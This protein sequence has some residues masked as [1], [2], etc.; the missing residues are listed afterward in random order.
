MRSIIRAILTF[1]LTTAFACA[2]ALAQGRTRALL[3]ACSD[4]VSQ[5]DLG[6]A[7]SGNLHMI[8]S[9]LISADVSQNGLAIEDG[10]IGT[11]E[12]LDSAIGSAFSGSAEDDLSI[13]YLCTHGILSSADDGEIYLLLGDGETE[14]PLSAGQLY[15]L[16]RNI[17]GE[18]LLI[19]DACHSGALIGRGIPTPEHPD[20]RLP[21]SR[22]EAPAFLS[23]FLSDSSVHV[24]T[25]AGGNESSWY[26]D[27]KHLSSGA[28]SYFASAIASGLGLY[29]A[30]EADLSGDGA[31]TL[32]ELH[33]YLSTAV[34]SS[35]SQLLSSRAQTLQL[36]VAGRL[37]LS[38]P[39][40]GFSYGSSLLT[41]KRPVLDFSFTVANETAV[42]YRLVEYVDGSW[43]WE[44]A[45]TF[46]DEGEDGTALLSAGRRQRS[47]TLDLSPDE[48]GYLML[49][50][51]SVS[52]E[53]LILCSERLIAV[54]P[55]EGAGEI[56]LLCS[57]ELPN[58]GLQELSISILPGVP[59]EVSAS[60]L[61]HEGR[62]VRR[63][64]SSRLTPPSPNSA[65]HLYWDGRDEDGRPVPPGTYTLTAEARIGGKRQ[66][67]VQP[68]T[69]GP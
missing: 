63:L 20:I 40:S 42:Q 21:G 36:P 65:L 54:Q 23:P 17:Q 55:L 29:G 57:G 52:D 68:V 32:A 22:A 6:S 48:I 25:S 46:M 66:K 10:T 12:A 3:V 61:D 51:F 7:S 43:D 38:R 14:T 64:A 59:A 37:T 27:S 58:P 33:H 50:V 28:V 35:S 2:P 19:I 49:Q 45:Q 47:L 15:T 34:P 60:V 8:A 53:S 18:K 39:L 11:I 5:V 16:I 9:A 69:V 4:F 62:L 44:N 31:V 24:L 41:A 26:Y 1:I 56:R 30:P 67:A 13:L